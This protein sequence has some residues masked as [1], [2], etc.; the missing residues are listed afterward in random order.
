MAPPREALAEHAG[1]GSEKNC[2]VRSFHLMVKCGPI[3]RLRL[4]VR[5]HHISAKHTPVVAA[6]GI[7]RK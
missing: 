7:C 3:P 2:D 6:P 4:H 1:E 5:S